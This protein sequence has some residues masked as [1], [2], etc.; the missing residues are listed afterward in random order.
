MCLRRDDTLPSSYH[1]D[2]VGKYVRTHTKDMPKTHTRT[3]RKTH[4]LHASPWSLEPAWQGAAAVR[5]RQSHLH[6][7][8][9][10]SR[11]ALCSLCS[12]TLLFKMPNKCRLEC[13]EDS[14]ELPIATSVFGMEVVW[15]SHEVNFRRP[16][17]NE[18]ILSGMLYKCFFCVCL[19]VCISSLWLTTRL[20][21]SLP[22]SYNV[23]KLNRITKCLFKTRT[24]LIATRKLLH[25]SI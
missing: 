18:Q 9:S 5:L 3:R 23:S 11:P 13:W 4:D 19:F 10:Q 1:C 16:A 25:V 22:G 17:E 24:T 8:K 2:H 20:L 15:K 6:R 14:A 12:Q 7:P 21:R